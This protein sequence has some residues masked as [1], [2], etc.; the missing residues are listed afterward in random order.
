M[1][2]LN[3]DSFK[4]L[5]DKHEIS[6]KEDAYKGGRRFKLD[7]CLFDSNHVNGSACF[8]AYPDGGVIYKCQ[9]DS[10]ENYHFPD[11]IKKIEPDFYK[12]PSINDLRAWFDEPA[13]P[14]G[15]IKLKTLDEIEERTAEWLSPGRI[16]K[17]QITIIAGDGGCGKTTVWCSIAAAI[18]AGR[19]S[20]FE[21]AWNDMPVIDED[22]LGDWKRKPQKVLYFS[23]EDSTGH[24]LKKRLRKNNAVMENIKTVDIGDEDL[25]S[26]KFSSPALE[27]ILAAEQPALCIFDPIQSFLG[28]RTD[29][30]AR[31][32]MR[33]E[34]A[35]LIRYGDRYGVTFLLMMHTNKQSNVWGRK[36][37]ADSADLWDIARSV[38]VMGET[39]EGR[40]RYI[41]QEKNN[42]GV[43]EP[44]IIF[45][46]VDGVPIYEET[47]NKKDREF[48]S[49]AA[50]GVPTVT[51]VSAREIMLNIIEENGEMRLADL[52]QQAK[53]CS[54]GKPTYEK[55]RRKLTAEKQI[56]I[57][58]FSGGKGK[59]VLW[60]V[61]LAGS[62]ESYKP[63]IKS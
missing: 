28:N 6:Y 18:S 24:V 39:G 60:L 16:P 21:D 23:G 57:R 43:L 40:Q 52:W 56:I 8:I 50:K 41:S 33:N 49:A 38:L 55:V 1:K 31:N 37:L 51:E 44:T 63:D 30:K 5:L 58:K 9:H 45:S 25:K 26:I 27:K 53:E 11:A 54:I 10:C 42:Y 36:R 32:E 62:P 13:A 59:G 7:H 15:S 17:N 3:A 61:R 35:S 46:I 47:T 48:V 14:T 19:D 34:L 22:F 20:I 29:M 2:A 4:E 12:D